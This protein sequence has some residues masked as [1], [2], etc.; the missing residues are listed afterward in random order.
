MLNA[1]VLNE[2]GTSSHAALQ[3]VR[4]KLRAGRPLVVRVFGGSVSAGHQLEEVYGMVRGYSGRI[5]HKAV[6]PCGKRWNGT[7]E[8]RLRRC[9]SWAGQFVAWLNAEYPASGEHVLQN[10][11]HAGSG[12]SYAA[13]HVDHLTKGLEP[14]DLVLVE[15]ALNDATRCQLD[16][17][18]CLGSDLMELVQAHRSVAAQPAVIFLEFGMG[19]HLIERAEQRAIAEHT[20]M[21]R[22]MEL[23]QWSLARAWDEAIARKLIGSPDELWCTQPLT[24][25]PDGRHQ[26]HPSFEGHALISEYVALMLERSSCA[27]AAETAVSHSSAVQVVENERADTVRVPAKQWFDFTRRN[28]ARTACDLDRS[29]GCE[30]V[31]GKDLVGV[32][33]AEPPPSG[34][35]WVNEASARSLSKFGVVATHPAGRGGGLPCIAFDIHISA[36]G[37]KVVV[38]FLRSYENMGRATLSMR[39]NNGLEQSVTVDGLWE[40]R[41]SQYGSVTL[42]VVVGG[43]YVLII[44]LLPAGHHEKRGQNKFKLLDILVY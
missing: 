7:L 10:L 2:G 4:A 30:V 33:R 23:P 26:K 17:A 27:R 14:A 24:D 34:W 6:W 32:L 11:A 5:C 44:E 22:K 19:F 35:R 36:E 3:R 20:E 41:S 42:P 25:C 18:R 21:C 37:K 31:P 12:T 38:G 9:Y 39:N 40:D 8:E 16:E 13:L 29:S 15:T 28:P 1:S 43:A